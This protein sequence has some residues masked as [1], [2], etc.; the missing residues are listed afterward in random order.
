MKPRGVIGI[1]RI[2]AEIFER[3]HGDGILEHARQTLVRWPVESQ[4]PDRHYEEADDGEIEVAAFKSVG[5]PA[6]VAGI[7]LNARGRKLVEPGKNESQREAQGGRGDQSPNDPAGGAETR[8]HELGD[9]EQ[10]PDAGQIGQSYP[11]DVASFELPPE[12]HPTPPTAPL[13]G[14]D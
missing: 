11:D 2:R 12:R 6:A 1:V 7:G 14:A 3:Q 9:L 13:P 8:Q 10:Q 5:V 4:N